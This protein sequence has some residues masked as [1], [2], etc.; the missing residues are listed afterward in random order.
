MMRIKFTEQDERRELGLVLASETFQKAPNLARLLHYICAKHWEG[1]ATELKEY[2]LGVEALGRPRD[3]DPS[4]SAIV[5]VEFY[6]LREKVKRFYETE[7]ANRPLV[8]TLQPGHYAPRF[9]PRHDPSLSAAAVLERGAPEAPPADEPE[10]AVNASHLLPTAAQAPNPAGAGKPELAE[11][12]PIFFR[13]VTRSWKRRVLAVS[14]LGAA[15][16]A[17][18][19]LHGRPTTSHLSLARPL[20]APVTAPPKPA[21]GAIRILAGYSRS[22]HIDSAGNTWLSDR[23]F[24]GGATGVNPN[25]F[26]FRSLDPTLFRTYRHGEFAYNIPLAP[27]VYELWLYFVETIYGPG[28]IHQGGETSRTFGI[29]ING[30]PVLDPFDTYADA[31]GAFVGDER[32][33]KDVSPGRNGYLQISFSRRQDEPMLTALEVL[34]GIPGKQRTIRIVAQPNTY[35]DH[36]GRVWMPDQFY[37]GGQF[38]FRQGQIE[39]TPEPGLYE[40]ERYGNFDYAI[41]VAQGNY[42]VTLYFSERYFGAGNPAGG[43]IGSR[44]FDVYCN[45]STLLKDFD[46]LKQAGGPNRPLSEVFHGLRPNAQGK[47]HISFIPVV[48]YAAVDAIKVVD[49]SR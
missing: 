25:H 4:A 39:G 13:L 18:V 19:L 17:L 15:L 6:R 3:F 16:L 49:E 21:D 34:P 44:L 36:K 45:G 22:S 37:A 23:Y 35:T 5:R 11:K 29:L 38:I 12:I 14:F 43:G 20:A 26:I 40:G 24:E 42:S 30:A 32:V 8:L 1:K 9:V 46:V 27:G 28:L 48:N 7:G 31:G 2:T 41:P 47:L 33:F 10:A